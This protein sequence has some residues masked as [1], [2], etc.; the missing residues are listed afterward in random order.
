MAAFAGVKDSINIIRTASFTES[1][2]NVIRKQWREGSMA[3]V[4]ETFS[5]I[6]MGCGDGLHCVKKRKE[7]VIELRSEKCPVLER[8]DRK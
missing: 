7:S 8:Y 4:A 6:F 1:E 2:K 5:F 3:R